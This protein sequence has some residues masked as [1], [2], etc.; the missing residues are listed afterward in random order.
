MCNKCRVCEESFVPPAGREW[1]NA[2]PACNEASGGYAANTAGE[3]HT[4]MTRAERELFAIVHESIKQLRAMGENAH[5]ASLERA[6]LAWQDEIATNDRLAE[7]D[8]FTR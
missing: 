4:A 1:Y 8:V 2:C 5:S 6:A 3:P 7:M